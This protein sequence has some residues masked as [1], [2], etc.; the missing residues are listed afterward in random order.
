MPELC[1]SKGIVIRMYRNEHPPSHFHAIHAEREA[2]YRL[3]GTPLQGEL[4]RKQDQLV[5]E[6]AAL[7]QQELHSCWNRARGDGDIGTIEPL[8]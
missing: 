8:T 2:T 7:R 4:P 3:D 5:R 1:R 6:W